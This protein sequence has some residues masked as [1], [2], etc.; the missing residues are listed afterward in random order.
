MAQ[1]MFRITGLLQPPLVESSAHARIKSACVPSSHAVCDVSNGE[2][3]PAIGCIVV[4]TGGMEKEGVC[5]E[6]VPEQTQ[7]HS[8]HS[9]LHVHGSYNANFLGY[10]IISV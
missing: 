9:A 7:L 3:V 1:A 5:N 4:A 10:G 2:C 6:T 8:Q